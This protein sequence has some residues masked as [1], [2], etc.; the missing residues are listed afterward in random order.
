MGLKRD[1]KLE[2]AEQRLALKFVC[3]SAKIS[4]IY[5][6]INELKQ[7]EKDVQLPVRYTKNGNNN[8]IRSVKSEYLVLQRVYPEKGDTNITLLRNEY[9]VIVEHESNNRLSKSKQIWKIIDKV[10]IIREEKFQVF[11]YNTTT[12]RKDVMWIY[13]NILKNNIIKNGKYS[14]CKMLIYK[15]KLII[16]FDNDFELITAKNQSDAIRLYNK[17]KEYLKRDKLFNVIFLGILS[18]TNAAPYKTMIH[19][20]TGW[21]YHKINKYTLRS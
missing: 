3:R 10:P 16:E 17:L 21:S 4:K 7:S 19:N 14:F 1:Y 13:D 18:H 20:K 11:G 2:I 9:G 5:A 8:G 6:K 15:N 12:D